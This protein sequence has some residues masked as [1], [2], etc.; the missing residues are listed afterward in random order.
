[1]QIRTATLLNTLINQYLLLL[2]N[3]FLL[4]LTQLFQQKT[5]NMLIS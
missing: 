4:K 3:I 1:M 2:R 5:A